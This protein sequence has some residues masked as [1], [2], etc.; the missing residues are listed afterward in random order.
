MTWIDWLIVGTFLVFIVGMGIYSTKY[1]RSVTDY[2]VC[3][4]VCGRYVIC[5]ADVACALALVTLV[6]VVEAQYKTGFLVGFWGQ[7]TVPVT[8]F[9]S[10]TGFVF[11]R[12]RQTKAMSF[13][14]FIEM[15]YSRGLRI[16]ASTLRS[17]SEILA[18]MILPALAGRFFIYFLD[19]PHYF[20][21]FGWR[22]ST[23]M[24]IM[25]ICMTM[26]VTMILL[27][28]SVTLVVTDT[29]QGLLAYPILALFVIFVLWKFSWTNEIM[30]VM[31]DRVKGESFLNPYDIENLRD[32][33][34][35]MVFFL[36][37]SSILNRGIGLGAGGGSNAAKTPHEQKMAGILGSWRGGFMGMFY[38]LLAI[39]II[40]FLNHKNFSKEATEARRELSTKITREIITDRKIGDEIIRKNLEIPPPYHTIGIDPP[41][42][43]TK[44]LD[45]PY[46]NT[47]IQVLESHPE[48]SQMRGKV[49]EFRTL[50]HQLMLPVVMR[51]I[52]PTGLKGLF[53][54]L[55]IL[56]II[57]T[58]DSRIFSAS[59][60]L[61]QDLVL[62]LLKKP[63][64]PK[65]HI[66]I[67]RFVTIGIGILFFFGSLYM[68]QL[69]YIQLFIMIMWGIWSAGAGS[70]VLGGLYTRFG[71]KQGAWASLITGP[72]IMIAG[73]LM[74]RN[75]AGL[76]YP[77]LEKNGWSSGIGSFLETVS[78]PFNPY[79]VWEMNPHKFP[80]NAVEISFIAMVISLFM[81][82]AISLL[83]CRKPFNLDCMLHR[84]K[85]NTEHLVEKKKTVFSWKGLFCRII[86]ITNE[87]SK[88]DRIIAWSVFFYTF[89]L[90]FGLFLTVIVWN[91]F[92][93]WPSNWWSNYFLIFI[94]IIPGIIA[95]VSTVWFFIGGLIDLRK[96]FQALGS[97]TVDNLDNGMVVGN[98]SLADKE[99]FEEIEEHEKPEK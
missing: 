99:K 80:I 84:G 5:V 59:L 2:L 37:F 24:T 75:W 53:C 63:P 77:W 82:C 32:F 29:V 71:T 35:F 40:V 58:D 76:V 30:P 7:I 18:N 60:T 54:L 45:T 61:S 20:T 4:R 86:G 74:Q 33:N 66:W 73:I 92:Y 57:S 21:L 10:L 51:E 55:I 31:L 8:L 12:F 22:I 36:V 43:Q 72:G 70:V 26:V 62:P 98:V 28:G 64:T 85:Y 69:D 25:L 47:V 79:I 96:M 83:T 78:S 6:G 19:L 3:G 90:G 1:V 38:L 27:G 93:R 81:Y 17:V 39:C 11:Y 9:L 67:I 89:G 56:M 97:R 16:F 48:S 52:L 88:G 46:V 23:F 49:Q 41:L 50:F 34:L 42:S 94:M 91:L 13:G 65:Q 14:Q 95:V 15:R 44:N 87:Y 68:S